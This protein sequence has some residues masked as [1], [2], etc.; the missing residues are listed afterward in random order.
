MLLKQTGLTLLGQVDS[1]LP[2]ADSSKLAEGAVQAFVGLMIVFTALILLSLF[3]AVLV[4]GYFWVEAQVSLLAK[5][6]ASGLLVALFVVPALGHGTEYA[7]PAVWIGV[8]ATYLIGLFFWGKLS[9][10]NI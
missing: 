1:S 8:R 7:S 3:I 5:S 9:N 10:I 2:N 4:L 6:T